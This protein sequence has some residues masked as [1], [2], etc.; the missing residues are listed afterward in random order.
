MKRWPLKLV[1]PLAIVLTSGIVAVFLV[2]AGARVQTQ[3]AED[4]AR[5]VRAAAV[6]PQPRYD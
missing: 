6:E 5:L 4:F 3:P 2:T 1:L